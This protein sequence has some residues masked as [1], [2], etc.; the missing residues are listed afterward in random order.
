M[1]IRI[2]SRE[3]RLAIA[4]AKTAADLL[5]ARYPNMEPEIVTMQTSGDMLKD[6]PLDGAGGKG[7]F[8]RELDAALLE[9][10][11]DMA[12]HSLKDMAAVLPEGLVISAFCARE[13]PRDALVLPR[14]AGE[15][16]STKPAGCSAKRRS[17][18]LASLYPGISCAPVRGNVTT[19]LAKLDAGEYG[20][21]VLA[22]A[23]LKRLGLGVR[24]SRIFDVDEMLPAAGQGVLA[25]VTR[26]EGEAAG[27]VSGIDDPAL[28][29]R[30]LAERTFTRILD[31]NCGLPVAAF[32]CME[33]GELVLQG[34][35]CPEGETAMISCTL[36]GDPAK[37][38]ELGRRLA[39]R[40]LAEAAGRKNRLGGVCL[41]GAGP[42]DAGLLTAR[43]EAALAEA[44]VVVFDRLV[45]PGILARIPPEAEKIFAGKERG[46][47]SL[48]Q[49][50]IN[51]LLVKKAAAGLRVVRL[52]GGDPLLFGRGGEEALCLLDAGISCEIVPGIS[53]ALAA[54]GSAG[55]PLT[56]RGIA[57][58]V[59]IIAAHGEGAKTIDYPAL[60]RQC[61]SGDSLVFLMGLSR[62][63]RIC[64]DLAAAGLPGSTPAAIVSHG[65]T[66]KE[67]KLFAPAAA[68]A[69][70][71]A[72]A[73]IEPPAVIVVGQA[74]GLAEAMAFRKKPLFGVRIAVTR[75]RNGGV[76]RLAKMLDARG[77]EVIAL[78]TIRIAPIRET[79]VLQEA[80][81]AA[82][83]GNIWF[84][85]TSVHG[86]EAFFEKLAAYR[87]DI[88]T[89]AACKF[90]AIGNAA[91]AALA[92]RGI[93]PDLAPDTFSGA[94][95]GAALAEIAAK[96][97]TV[98]LPR[99][100]IGGKDILEALDTAGLRYIDIPVYDTV[101]E[102]GCENP[103][104][105]ERLIQGL[106]YL[107]FT[108]P[109]AVEGFARIFGVSGIPALCIGEA[110]A[111]PARAYGMEA[112]VPQT[113]SLEGMVEALII[114]RLG[115]KAEKSPL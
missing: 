74:C 8:T 80:L 54:P 56:H 30:S 45:G 94:A 61:A 86:V 11:I 28:R 83:R 20:A 100:A 75:P 89:L 52:K 108:S 9:G 43:S 3:S 60:V 81:A 69:A 18:Q 103:A 48:P 12:V 91:C 5:C 111:A 22:A 1:V 58:R 57:S 36:Q 85:F 51:A 55:I 104:F 72:E 33:G 39:F 70:R 26:A 59:H 49:E 27:L 24:A 101:P 19:R 107:A 93:I 10:R 46:H 40:L 6:R 21:L 78:P 17:I 105:R 4:Q 88:R 102:T 73:G 87:I 66:S 99:S 7:L 62:L 82:P 63:D 44:D 13:D 37:P 90:A 79:P 15:P 31:G 96:N 41:V 77:A 34:R 112:I 23:G 65:T 115:S 35:C 29:Q 50:E 64:R 38:E 110:T 98:I 14:G 106:D 114:S 32:A 42:G 71:A 95:L 2:G 47:H 76:N 92:S 25:V 68:L 53:S 97:E 67:R 16:D 113:S 84:A 109:S